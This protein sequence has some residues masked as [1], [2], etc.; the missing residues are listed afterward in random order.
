M[1]KVII[2][3]IVILII[4]VAAYLI[5]QNQK[6][7]QETL[8]LIE[9]ETPTIDENSSY[10]D[11]SPAQAYALIMD[12]KIDLVV[13]DVSP[14]YDDGHLPGAVGYYLG[15]DSLDR[16]IPSL[17]KNKT[18]LV[19]CHVDRVAISGAEKL[20]ESGI[21][22]V[23]RLEGNYSAWEKG[24]YPIEIE[25]KAVESYSGSGLATSSFLNGKFVHTVEA[26]LAEPAAGKFYE[27]WLVKRSSFFST[28]KLEKKNGKYV[29]EYVS[30]EDNRDYTQ[31][32]ITEETQ[33]NGLD[34]QPET[35]VLEGEFK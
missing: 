20:A 33:A 24:G 29:L 8:P 7:G 17:D 28:G 19:Y 34:G 30:D 10:T 14:H 6:T 32:V 26:D 12:P 9:T 3:I 5:W 16:V 25:I 11:I 15:D 13:I 1:K 21:M 27:G 23:F 18:Y 4:A 35:H 31:V 2:T 22:K